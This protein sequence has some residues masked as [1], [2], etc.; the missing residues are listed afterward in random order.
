M[1]PDDDDIIDSEE[2]FFKNEANVLNDGSVDN[3]KV[4]ELWSEDLCDSN[5]DQSD[6]LWKIIINKEIYDVKGSSSQGNWLFNAIKQSDVAMNA[7][8]NHHKLIKFT[9]ITIDD[10]RMFVS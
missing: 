5:S 9:V 4:D 2:K 6:T 1:K 7:D 8:S 3:A 10:I